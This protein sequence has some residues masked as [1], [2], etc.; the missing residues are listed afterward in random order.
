MIIKMK[1]KYLFLILILC[2]SCSDNSAIIMVCN[3][4][5]P[6]EELVWLKEIKT[7]FEQSASVSKK[8]IIQY[9]YQN[10]SVFLIDICNDCA[11]NLTAVYNCN[12][13]LICEFGG[14]AGI[15]TCPDFDKNVTNKIILWKN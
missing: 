9:T 12:G 13:T 14:I 2:I 10:K 15:N 5:N 1:L 7:G 4:N 6:L 8:K 11:D 3:T